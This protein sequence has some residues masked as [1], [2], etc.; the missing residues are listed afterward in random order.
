MESDRC[1]ASRIAISFKE[2]DGARYSEQQ[3][4]ESDGARHPEQLFSLKTVMVP[5]IQRSSLL[6][7]K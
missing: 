1:Q 4:M 5:G 7:G 3:F 6:H 2:G